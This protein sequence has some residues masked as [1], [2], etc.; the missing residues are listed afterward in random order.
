MVATTHATRHTHKAATV[1]GRAARPLG[2]AALGALLLLAPL[3]ACTPSG[4]RGAMAPP[5]GTGQSSAASTPPGLPSTSPGPTPPSPTPIGPS[6]LDAP[7]AE[8]RRYPVHTGIVATTFWV[9]EIFDANAEDGSQMLSTYDSEWF[10]NYGGC[11]GDATSGSC[12]TEPR[13]AANDFFPLS[14]TPRLN[15][16]YLDLPFDD[17]NDSAAF[18]RRGAVVPWA[19]DP[20]YLG[21]AANSDVSFMLNRWVKI[22]KGDR[23]CFGQIAD[24]GPGQY[25]DAEYVFG[26]DDAR[27]LN[28]EFN[29]AGMDV[30]PAL[31]GCLGFSELNGEDDRVSWQFVDE[32]DVPS[33]PWLRLVSRGSLVR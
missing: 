25:N 10:A 28:R 6:N 8:P 31:N 2:A 27:P 22:S 19:G 1:P 9:G 3:T 30:S 20:E 21:Q 15:P 23:V 7:P 26:A 13:T 32:G 5:S 17:V 4:A 11:D 12:E 18:A 14:M 16:F 29:G 33:G 24:A